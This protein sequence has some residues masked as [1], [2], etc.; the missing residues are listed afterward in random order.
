MPLGG[1]GPRSINPILA[2]TGELILEQAHITRVF[3]AT[4]DLTCTLTANVVAHN[5]SAWAEVQ[6][7]GGAKLSD[8]NG[9]Q[10]LHFS[11]IVIEWCSDT[12]KL[13]QIEL[14]YGDDKIAIAPLRIISGDKNFLPPIQ[15]MRIR[16]L[17][18]V[19]GE[20]IYYRMMSETGGATCKVS[21][22]YHF[23]N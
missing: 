13:Y 2:D 1:H 5:W 17:T 11:S 7:S 16:A 12:D 20:K 19:I 9:S 23:H 14:A 4:T 21:F 8:L 6:D 18:I 3:P 10:V 15:Q 22:R